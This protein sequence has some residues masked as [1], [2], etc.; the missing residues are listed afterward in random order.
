MR[1]SNL[2]IRN[3]LRRVL[4]VLTIMILKRVSESISF[5]SN[6]FTECKIKV[7][8]EAVKYLM[9]FNLLKNIHSF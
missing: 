9:A 7:E 2:P 1:H 4:D 3:T 6:K 5:Q 8:K